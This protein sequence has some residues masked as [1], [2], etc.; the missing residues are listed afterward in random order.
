MDGY[1]FVFDRGD[2][3]S[4][5]YFSPDP[6]SKRIGSIVFVCGR[7]QVSFPFC[8]EGVPLPRLVDRARLSNQ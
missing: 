8:H 6:L 5:G 2:P 3:I 7:S 4:S 1:Y